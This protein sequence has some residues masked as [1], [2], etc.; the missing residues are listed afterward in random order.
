VQLPLPTANAVENLAGVPIRDAWFEATPTTGAGTDLY[1]L[2]VLATELILVDGGTSLAHAVDELLS[3][4]REARESGAALESSVAQLLEQDPR[5]LQ[6]L[7]PQ[8]LLELDLAPGEALDMVGPGSWCAVLSFLIRL[9]P[10]CAEDS[11]APYCEGIPGEIPHRVFGPALAPLEEL[12][13]RTRAMLMHQTETDKLVCEAIQRCRNG[14][15]G[16]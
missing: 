8:R 4:A 15:I 12:V 5:W 16:P 6:S 1:S 11:F 14:A 10:G 13:V 3:L 7:G 2:A 9:F